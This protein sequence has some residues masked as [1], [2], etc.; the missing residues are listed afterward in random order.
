MCGIAGIFDRTGQAVERS[1]LARMNAQLA[2]RG[3]DDEGYHI[4]GS[5]GLAQR[6]LRIIDLATGRQP[7]ANEDGTVW[8]TFNGEIYNFREFRD[9]LIQLGHRF[10]TASDTEVIVHGYEQYGA[11]CLQKMRGMFAFAIWDAKRHELFL[12]RDR[13]GK[14]PLF[15]AWVG[16]QFVFASELQGLLQHPNIKKE[17]SPEAIDE[18][19]TY[20]YIPAPRT[21]FRNIFKLLPGHYLTVGVEQGEGRLAEPQRYWQLK[22]EPKQNLSEQEA[23]EAFLEIMKEAIRLRLIADVPLGALLSGGIDSSL[24]VALMSQMT[25]R[26][27]K[28]FSIGFDDQAFNEL[29][30]ARLIAKRYGTE[31]HEMVVRPSAL[32]ILPLLVRHYGE[33]F[34]DSSAVPSYYVAQMTRQHVTVALNGDGGDECFAGYDRYL[35]STMADR[36]QR[37]PR[38]LRTRLL[39][40]LATLI[41]DRLPR[42]HRLGQLKRFIKVAGESRP[43][44]YIQWMSYFRPAQKQ[45]LY[46]P[47]FRSRLNEKEATAWLAER[48]GAVSRNGRDALDAILA[49]DI[50]SYLPYDLLVKMDIASMANSLEARSPFLDHKVLEFTATLPAGMKIRGKTLKYLLKKSSRDLLPPEVLNR[51]KMGFGVPVGDWMRGDLRP[52]LDDVLLSDESLQRG[53][54]DPEHVRGLVAAHIDGR[55]NNGDQLWALLWLELWHREFKL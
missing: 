15:Y 35:G 6:R 20:G 21:A 30:F 37:I 5:I 38:V 45:K 18:Y 9:E 3:P 52:L 34:A 29:P 33:P 32:E 43:G 22:Y 42:R 13:V 23:G 39:E 14:K 12:A 53:Y 7:M 2:H 40:P 48:Y 1:I 47:E 24:V 41:P 10:A 50:E 31:H 49:L 54:F 28:T 8:V 51:R 36:Y 44:R 46:S 26:P 11:G 55:Q 4:S 19:L 16:G 27:V 17:V 25:D